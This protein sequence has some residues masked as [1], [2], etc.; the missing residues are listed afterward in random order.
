V[1]TPPGP[2]GRALVNPWGRLP[3]ATISRPAF[4][5]NPDILSLVAMVPATI[6]IL[7][8]WI[9]AILAPL[10]VVRRKRSVGTIVQLFYATPVTP[11]WNS[12]LASNCLRRRRW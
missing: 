6:P 8:L 7:L 2:P 5:Y 4:G 11:A 9:P 10:S 3:P 12:W 1:Q